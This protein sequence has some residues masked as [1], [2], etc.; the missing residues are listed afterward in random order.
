ME[1]S[2]RDRLGERGARR[3][4]RRRAR[5]AAV[6]RA[7]S[8]HDERGIA[9][10]GRALLAARGRAGRDRAA[11][12]AAGRAAARRRPA[13]AGDP[14]QPGQG[15]RAPRF[16]AAAG[17]S[18]R[19]D[20]LRAGRA[21]PHRR[22]TASAR[23]SP[24]SDETKALRA[25]TRARE[26]L[27]AAAGRAGQPAARPARRASGPAP[28]LSS[29]TSTA[30]SRSRSSSATPAPPTPAASAPSAWPRFLARHALLRPHRRPSEL[31][32]AAAPGAAR[33]RR[34]ARDR[35]PPRHRPRPGR[36]AASRSS[37]Q[38]SQLTA[39]DPR[40][41]RRPPRRRDLPELFRDPKSGDLR[42]RPCS[43]RSAT[44]ATATPPTTAW[45]PTPA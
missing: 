40:R 35:R 37:T 12:R 34:R 29:P 45:P 38:I 39:P 18:D 31:V 6:D 15:R 13:G 8:R 43:P 41:P 42:R 20:A 33:P 19:F 7:S 14:P 36:R 23:W 28:T 22:A 32:D 1:R 24:D 2:A 17:K 26:D 16:R 30:R 9:R 3:L 27:V 11:R 44:A 5:R 21:G 4:H 10:A 25:L